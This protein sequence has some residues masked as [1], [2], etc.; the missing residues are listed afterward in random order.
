MIFNKHISV[1]MQTIYCGIIF[2]EFVTETS[3]G[4]DLFSE[5]KIMV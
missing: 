2:P 5:L 1:G 4:W 3:V